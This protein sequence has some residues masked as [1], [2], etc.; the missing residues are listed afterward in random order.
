VILVDTS[1]LLW[2]FAASRRLGPRARERLDA[3]ASVHYSPIS[4]TELTIKSMLG[5]VEV[6]ADFGDL[7]GQRGL[8]EAPFTSADAA[9]VAEFPELAKHD[10][11]DRMLVAQAYRSGTVLLTSDRALL[12][13]A[14]DFIADATH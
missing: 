13:L 3:A 4:I 14:R 8:T 2:I 9:A 1:V 5:K 11:F 10:P 12:A 6:P 7:A